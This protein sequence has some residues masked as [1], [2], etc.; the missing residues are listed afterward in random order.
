MISAPA[1]LVVL[2]K[3]LNIHYSPFSSFGIDP[4]VG[5]TGNFPFHTSSQT[6]HLKSDIRWKGLRGKKRIDVV[7]HQT[8]KV[9]GAGNRPG[10]EERLSFPN[11]RG[12]PLIID[13]T[14]KRSDQRPL[15]ARRAEFG[16]DSI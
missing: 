7:S 15:M 10:P 6:V 11:L 8:G 3:K 5:L 12:I 16:I 2:Q 14:C 1:K 4:L 9:G 13:K